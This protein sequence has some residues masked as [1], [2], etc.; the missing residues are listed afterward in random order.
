MDE[1][2][3]EKLLNDLASK[4]VD[5]AGAAGSAAGEALKKAAGGASKGAIGRAGLFE[6]IFQ[7][8][9]TIFYW[10][11]DG[12]LRGAIDRLRPGFDEK[13]FQ[14]IIAGIMLDNSKARRGVVEGRG[15]SYFWLR[16]GKKIIVFRVTRDGGLEVIGVT[17]T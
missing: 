8:Y 7:F 2:D 4:A 13:E 1:S 3:L 17:G 15:K 10:V 14:E 6:G 12:E 5:S 11:M 9:A 16:Q